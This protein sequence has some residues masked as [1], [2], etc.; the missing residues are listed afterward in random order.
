[1]NVIPGYIKM[2]NSQRLDNNWLWQYYLENGG[3]IK[4]KEEFLDNFYYEKIP[5]QMNGINLGYQKI[6]RD[7]T[8]FFSDMDR[9]LDVRT[10]WDVNNNFIKV[11]E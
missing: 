10:L 7:L 11:V 9:K 2:R 5:V 4:N 6:E 3:K 8:N 1:M